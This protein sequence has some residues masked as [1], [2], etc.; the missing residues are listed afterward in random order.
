[1]LPTEAL[2]EACGHRGVAHRGVKALPTEALPEKCAHKGVAQSA[3]KSRAKMVAALAAACFNTFDDTLACGQ[4]LT[5]VQVAR[6]CGDRSVAHRGVKVLPTEAL[7]E[8]CGHRGVAHRG[9]QALPTESR[10]CRQKR[11][12]QRRYSAAHRGVV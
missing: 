11:G 2:S 9:V 6:E 3:P 7:S 4:E 8:A 10:V 12:P 1:M 5:C